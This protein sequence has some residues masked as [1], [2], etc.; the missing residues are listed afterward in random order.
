MLMTQFYRSTL[1]ISPHPN[2]DANPDVD[3]A[4]LQVDPNYKPHCNLN[5]KP[6]VDDTF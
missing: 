6:D 4:L 5:L 1:F 3:D 2:P